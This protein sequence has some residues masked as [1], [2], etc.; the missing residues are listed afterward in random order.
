MAKFDKKNI[1]LSDDM[2]Q[3]KKQIHEAALKEET[4][5]NDLYQ[6][7]KTAASGTV[8]TLNFISSILKSNQHIPLAGFAIQMLLTLVNAIEVITDSKTSIAA[9]I[10]AT[11]FLGTI[12]ALSI[13]AVV[14]GG[15]AAAIIGT[16]VSSIATV[17]EGIG[18]LGKAIAKYQTSQDY[19]NKNEFLELVK[20][21]QVPEGDKFNEL[22]KIRAIEL[23]HEITNEHLTKGEIKKLSKERDFITEVLK[24][25]NI[26]VDENKDTS[27]PTLEELYKNR[28]EKLAELVSLVGPTTLNKNID[29]IKLLQEEILTID[30]QIKEITAPIEK[31]ALDQ[32]VANEKLALSVGNTS[33]SA[34]GLVM[35]VIGI[36]LIVGSVAAPPFVLPALI[37][38]G[39]AMSTL[40]LIKWGM[41]KVM[42]RQDTKEM[43][44]KAAEHK[45]SILDEALFN[46]EHQLNNNIT[47]AVAPEVSNDSESSHSKY[48]QTLMTANLPESSPVPK[49]DLP[50]EPS[51]EK[52]SDKKF[53]HH[54]FKKQI[55][56]MK[57]TTS[58]PEET[59]LN[60][61]TPT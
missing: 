13:A 7:G 25:K 46:Y 59:T 60:N 16:V 39:I 26:A 21:R 31:L 12:A 6:G 9:K 54:E 52:N 10:L 24:N 49:V 51:V 35:S 42:E 41:E 19:D 32:L 34:F 53:D 11:S 48:M 22:F 3:L 37:G 50:I 58:P 23:E 55:T 29:G 14:V 61:L 44:Q 38:L 27:A 57:E 36:V 43:E 5:L 8:T 47:V 45:E 56:A 20:L 15:F 2:N 30:E 4:L 40:S 18:L 28:E 33:M 1:Q 17:I